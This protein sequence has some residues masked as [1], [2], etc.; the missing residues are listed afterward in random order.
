MLRDVTGEAYLIGAGFVADLYMRSFKTFPGIRVAG[1]YDT[2]PARLDKFCRYWS[3]PHRS[4]DEIYAAAGEKASSLVLNLTNPHAHFAVSKAALEAGCAVYSEKPLAM[5]MKD[6]RA[7]VDIA[8]ASGLPLGSAP[9]SWLSDAA[10][11]LW[12]AVDEGVAGATRLVYAELDDGF[13]T[14]APYDLWRSESGAPWP[15]EDEFRVGCT[16]EHA[17]YYLTWLM[18][19]FGP[20]ER[21]VAASATVVPDKLPNA[22]AGA[23]DF[24]TASLFFRSGVV[25]RLTCSIAA[26]HDHRL[27]VIG[28]AGELEIDDC[29]NNHAPV[30]FRKRFSVRRRLMMS[31]VASRVEADE[32]RQ[33]K[34]GRFGAAAMNF[35]L[36]PANMLA[37]RALGRAADMRV[38]FALHVNEATLAIQN[39]GARDAVTEMTTT[40][41]PLDRSDLLV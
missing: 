13:I 28:D 29:W 18:A 32:R 19:I 10:R 12:R 8:S 39:A 3:A 24:S 21:I 33:P 11:A 7:L 31:P 2:D 16:L 30:R 36:G 4:L 17:G 26:R 40:F 34:I 25:A 5:E 6:A 22:D 15:A 1:V 23:P 9:C 27:R 14:Q 41:A 20:V 38:D 37:A 35:A